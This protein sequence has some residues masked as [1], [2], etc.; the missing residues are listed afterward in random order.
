MIRKSRYIIKE[1]HIKIF[2]RY[3]FVCHK[4]GKP[5]HIGD[6]I[7]TRGG[8]QVTRKKYY[9]ISCYDKII[10]NKPASKIKK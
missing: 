8:S 9:H 10:K 2:L 4:C 1:N 7:V 5:L 6:E 3:Y